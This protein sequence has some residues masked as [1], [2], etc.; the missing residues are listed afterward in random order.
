MPPKQSPIWDFFQEVDGDPSKVKCQI[1]GCKATVSR[2]KSAS[3]KSALTNTSMVSHLTKHH[4]KEY[5]IFCDKKDNLDLKKRKEE[6]D[7]SDNDMENSSVPVFDIRTHNKRQKFLQQ[8]TLSSWAVKNSNHIVRS[9][10][11]IYSFQDLRAKDKHKGVLMM[12]ILDLE[13]WTIVDNPG[14]I[15]NSYQL[16][17][18]YK[19]G[20]A[21]FYRNLLDKAYENGVKKTVEKIDVDNPKYIACQLD[22]WSAYRHGYMGLLISYLTKDW[23]RVS[24]CLACSPFDSNHTGEIIGE[25]LDTKLASW[26]V[27]DRTHV[28]ISDTAS[29]MIKSME[30][31]PNSM[32]HCGCLNHIMQLSINDEVF[33]KAEVKNIIAKVKVFTNYYEK[34]TLLSAALVK[35]QE[36]CGFEQV[37]QIVKDVKTRWNTTYDCLKRF[38]E[39]K[40]PIN[41]IL[42]DTEWKNKL[43]YRE[44]PLKYGSHEWKV[45]ESLV[46]VLEPFKEATLSLSRSSASISESIPTVTTIV[47]ALQMNNG[48]F[49]TGVKDLKN[50]LRMNLLSR[51]E[52]YESQDIYALATLLDPRFKGV[53]FRNSECA[54]AAKEKLICILEGDNLTYDDVDLQE[55]EKPNTNLTG[56]AAIFDS[57]KK[58]ANTSAGISKNETARDIVELYL[59]GKLEEKSLR[60]WDNYE[61][62][63]E[64]SMLRLSLCELAKKYLTPHPTSTNCERLFSVAGQ[65][66]DDRRAS[67]LPENL[68]KILFLRENMLATN[69]SLD[70]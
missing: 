44:K 45:M 57:F 7:N 30:F 59:N 32:E 47:H 24:L 37:K 6:E 18:H 15:F 55:V 3:A 5:K 8:S 10:G 52:D 19:V 33:E 70:W 60:W 22:G 68:E 62:L 17:P 51:V 31:L 29:N 67:M 34:S 40:E 14:Y 42:E 53:F 56:L 9:K 4:S 64:N 36:E 63:S 38:V 23:K 65:I 2:G 13:P 39:L 16:D 58:K 28:V 69:F 43:K 11:S 49:D 46:K 50:R 54:K 1:A 21:T 66:V 12:V 41:K 35:Q 20:S 61:K 26:K 48:E 27:L 25:W